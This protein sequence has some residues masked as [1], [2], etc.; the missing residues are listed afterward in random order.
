MRILPCRSLPSRLVFALAV[1]QAGAASATTFCFP[2]A[3]GVPGASGAPDWW[4]SPAPLDDPRWRGAA[5]FDHTGDYARFRV[6]VDSEAGKKYL[7]AS[8]EVRADPDAAAND[9]LYVGFYND[10]GSPATSTG[11]VFRIK[12]LL[13]TAISN[14]T[15]PG[16]LEGK[17]FYW[18]NTAATPDW[19]AVTALPDFPGW[20]A[21]D[22]R[23]DVDC[24]GS[25]CDA[26]AIRLRIPIDPA[27]SFSDPNSGA[28]IKLG[29]T[30]RFYY[31]IKANTTD[32]TN[33]LQASYQMPEGLGDVAD[34]NALPVPH[35]PATSSWQQVGLDTSDPSC[36]KGIDLSWDQIDVS[37]TPPMSGDDPH[38]ISLTR[39]NTF[40]ARPFNH[41]GA[42]LGAAAIAAKFRIAD[43][44]T[45]LFTSP[46][47]RTIPGC[48]AATGPTTGSVANNAQ[49]DLTCNWNVGMPDACDYDVTPRPAGCTSPPTRNGHQCVLVDL[50]TA[51]G[52]GSSLYFSSAS[53][54]RN[55]DF[56]SASEFKRQARVDIG[57]LAAASPTKEVY[58]YVKTRNMPR[59][60][61]A[62]QAR[63]PLDPVLAKRVARLEL[64]QR[65]IGKDKAELIKGM[66]ASGELSG[67]DVE[68]IMPTYMVYAWYD[69]GK[70]TKSGG[71][72]FKLL[73]P[74]PSFGYFVYHDGP[75]VGWSHALTGPGVTRIARDLYKV[76]VPSNGAVLINTTL[77][78]LEGSALPSNHLSWWI[79]IVLLA[80]IL[81]I[82]L[83]RRSSHH[84]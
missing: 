9:S 21:G 58:L 26:W 29:T 13:G 73:R 20:L 75:L 38:Q 59:V 1:A 40:H 71:R 28:G 48:T 22:A 64:G 24:A 8:W 27:G 15:F 41:T 67:S 43:W 61:T 60:V 5:S 77:S 72:T 46:T 35:F 11:N 53:A 80:I 68:K 32:V 16:N 78:A 14:G 79:L 2:P 42:A 17:S 3:S 19:A 25:V 57:G 33:P 10:T 49:F 45:V 39:T 63:A 76:G 34:E 54:Y 62:G 31:E 4:T 82:I 37:K 55:H 65:P 84:P 44:G 81:I 23:L 51:G 12:R 18:N 47:W 50:T 69:T 66:L 7:V 36:S 30:F 52:T 56:V 74:M 70:T 6:L 83:L